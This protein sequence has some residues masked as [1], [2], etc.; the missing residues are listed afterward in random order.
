MKTKA[1]AGLWDLAG[2]GLV[3][4]A[5]F[6]SA[7]GEEKSVCR[8][9]FDLYNE[10]II[11]KCKELEGRDDCWFCPCQCYLNGTSYV[12]IPDPTTGLPD[13]E[14]S[15]CAQEEPCTGDRKYWAEGCLADKE[16][17][18]STVDPF[19]NLDF[20]GIH[21]CDPAFIEAIEYGKCQ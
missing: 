12:F 19:Y 14:L 16:A 13:I 7:C 1:F 18:Q 9:A 3:V 15:H 17:C 21:I 8:K 11:A 6:L 10:S 5:F 2:N 20:G 4:L